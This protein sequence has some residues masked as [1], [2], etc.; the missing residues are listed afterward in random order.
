MSYLACP[1]PIGTSVVHLVRRIIARPP[2]SVVFS[3]E[4]GYITGYDKATCS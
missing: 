1:K 3:V 4:R 2:K